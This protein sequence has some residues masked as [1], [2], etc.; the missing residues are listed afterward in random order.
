MFRFPLSVAIATGEWL[1][2]DGLSIVDGAADC[3]IV[4]LAPPN[5]LSACACWLLPE[6]MVRAAVATMI[7]MPRRADT[8][9]WCLAGVLLPGRGVDHVGGLDERRGELAALRRGQLAGVVSPQ[10]DPSLTPVVA[11]LAASHVHRDPTDARGEAG[12]LT[13][14]PLV[15]IRLPAENQLGFRWWLDLR[16]PHL[17]GHV[18]GLVLGGEFAGLEQQRV[19][20]TAGIFQGGQVGVLILGELVFDVTPTL[21]VVRHYLVSCY[22]AA[23][24]P[25][26]PR[27]PS[28]RR[29]Q[30]LNRRVAGRYL[31]ACHAAW[32]YPAS[33]IIPLP[34]IIATWPSHR[35][36][37]RPRGAGCRRC[38]AA[39]RR[40]GRRWR[41][42]RE[43]APFLARLAGWFGRRWRFEHWHGDRRQPGNVDDRRIR[44]RG[45]TGA[46]LRNPIRPT[47]RPALHRSWRRCRRN[48]VA[49]VD[50][51]DRPGDGL[52][53]GGGTH[54][55]TVRLVAVDRCRLIGD[56]ETGVLEAL[57]C[58]IQIQAG[59]ARYLATWRAVDVARIGWR[60]MHVAEI[61][62]DRRHRLEPGACGLAAAVQVTAAAPA[63]WE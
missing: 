40:A 28:S 9:V 56:L 20:L 42:R 33:I 14:P 1:G 17:L 26:S 35:Q 5:V 2:A 16:E 55:G 43:R 12:K 61:G 41:T 44:R 4:T 49:G 50:R 47:N 52:T 15:G 54:H 34:T 22:G 30:I 19:R 11:E 63:Q 60:Q 62:G 24:Q 3:V 37:H 48:P 8:C 21:R 6:A 58:R 10:V 27:G 46:V 53:T 57:T 39:L 38:V 29:G 7:P 13:E 59:H 31:T 32:A 36:G 18:L 51:D 23:T 45:R 25:H